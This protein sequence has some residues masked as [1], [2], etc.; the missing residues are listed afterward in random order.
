MF[1]SITN[2]YDNFPNKVEPVKAVRNI[3][4]SAAIG[5]IGLREAV[6]FVRDGKE[7][8]VDDHVGITIV[9]ALRDYGFE[10]KSSVKVAA[11]SPELIINHLFQKY[12]ETNDVAYIYAA[13]EM[14]KTFGN[15]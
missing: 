15:E 3:F 5:K 11:V 7:I 1:I 13:C 10:V 4:S 14:K 2:G 9:N 6:E 12:L 8:E